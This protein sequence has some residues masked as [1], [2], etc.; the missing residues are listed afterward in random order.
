MSGSGASLGRLLV[1]CRAHLA[2]AAPAAPVTAAGAGLCF[3]ASQV[4]F[5]AGGQRCCSACGCVRAVRVR[6]TCPTAAVAC[7]C[8]GGFLKV[9]WQ[10]HLA[11]SLQSTHCSWKPDLKLA[12][13]SGVCSGTACY[14]L[15]T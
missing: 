9:L 7:D 10:A 14:S 13:P 12:L 11:L 6:A 4:K 15:T 8:R 5:R 2:G 1:L 3:G